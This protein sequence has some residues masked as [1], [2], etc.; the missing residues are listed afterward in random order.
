MLWADLWGN[1]CWCT[2]RDCKMTSIDHRHSPWVQAQNVMESLWG[3]VQGG[4]RH[5][6]A[7]PCCTHGTAS[8]CCLAP[9]PCS[10]LPSPNAL[11]ACLLLPRSSVVAT[12]H[13]PRSSIFALFDMLLGELGAV[14][15][16]PLTQPGIPARPN[17][18]H[19]QWHFF[20]PAC[21]QF[22][23]RAKQPFMG[24]R[25]RSGR[26]PACLFMRSH[27]CAV[28]AACTPKRPNSSP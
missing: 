8:A 16:T 6:A 28:H 9:C 26:V 21:A 23:L 22:C 15:A 18:A 12:I 7:A 4:R 25:S 2:S 5:V 17:P 20:H 14:V 1:F 13:Q 19:L 11:P 10:A 27:P 24:Q 3:L